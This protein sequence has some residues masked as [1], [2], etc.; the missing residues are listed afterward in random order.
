MRIIKMNI[1]LRNVMI[2]G[3]IT[4]C[5]AACA[6]TVIEGPG[7][8]ATF[9]NTIKGKAISVESAVTSNGTRFPNPGGLSPDSQPIFN[10]KIMLPRGATMGAAP[11]GR[12]LPEWV[13]FEWK[14]TLHPYSE[15]PS[16]PEAY[17]AWSDAIRKHYQSLPIKTERVAVRER[18]PQSVIDEVMESNRQR[19]TGKVSEKMLWVYFIWYE[20]GIKFRWELQK[21]CCDVIQAGG[22]EID[23]LVRVGNS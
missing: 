3:L 14:E 10:G 12:Q 2:L 22:D 9:N 17:A 19:K 11:D 15:P 20:R 6:T 1:A 18:I 8:T 21:G 23:G 13:E 4:S 5:L 7:M 16:V